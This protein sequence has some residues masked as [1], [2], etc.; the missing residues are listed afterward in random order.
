MEL[1]INRR[2]FPVTRRFNYL[3]TGTEAP[4]STP[5]V[6]A[7]TV[8]LHE[9]ASFGGAKSEVAEKSK[10]RLLSSKR[11]FAEIIHASEDEIAAVPSA[12]YGIN[13]VALMVSPKKGDNIVLNELEFDSNMYPWLKYSK[14][15]VEI[16]MAKSE[17]GIVSVDAIEKLVD[18]KTKVVTAAHVA[19]WSGYRQDLKGAAEVAHRHGAVWVVDGAASVGSVVTDVKESDVD[20]LAI[21]SHKWLLGPKGAGFLYVKKERAEKFDPPLPGWYGVSH[22]TGT[23]GAWGNINFASNASKFEVGTP[24]VISYVGVAAGMK[25][26]M[27]I[28]LRRVEKSISDLTQHLIEGLSGIGANVVTPT[29]R[30]LRGGDIVALFKNGVDAENIHKR[31][32]ARKIITLLIREGQVSKLGWDAGGLYISPCFFNTEEEIDSLVRALKPLIGRT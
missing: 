15:G 12:S 19:T 8:Y 11:L 18:D 31:L 24:P 2:Q 32:E 1:S 23:S 27:E 16:R 20:F 29:E 28:G 9:V 26:I 3:A 22:E 17:K 13:L 5:V 10:E 4:L 6:K 14:A 21:S 7:C 30:R 25:M